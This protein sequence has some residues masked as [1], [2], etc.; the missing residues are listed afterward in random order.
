MKTI[1]EHYGRGR[2]DNRRAVINENEY[3]YSVD[4]YLGDVHQRTVD[5]SEHSFWFAE[6][7]AENW[8]T[9]IIKD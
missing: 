6:E 7:I 9:G 3:K 2:F 4:L 1:S 8:I 5:A